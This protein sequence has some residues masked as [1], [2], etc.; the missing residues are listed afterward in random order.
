LLQKRNLWLNTSNLYH[1][2]DVFII[3]DGKLQI[4]IPVG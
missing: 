4:G 2:N 3:M 1:S